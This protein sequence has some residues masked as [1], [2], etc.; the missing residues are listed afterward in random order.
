MAEEIEKVIAGLNFGDRIDV[1][2]YD[3]S[4][5]TGVPPKDAVETYVHS[6]GF[7]IGTKGRKRKH[8]VFAKEIID[9]G[10]AYHYNA[11]LFIMIDR[12][13]IIQHDALDPKLKRRLKKFVRESIHELNEKDGWFYAKRFKKRIMRVAGSNPREKRPK[14]TQAERIHQ[15]EIRIAILEEQLKTR[16]FLEKI[17]WVLLATS[18]GKIVL[19]VLAALR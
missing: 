10:S 2:W 12:I 1:M 8:L 18:L 15:L 19:D 5:A 9:A 6:T 7:F 3:A 4:E 13:L 11:I 17:I 16:Q 14:K